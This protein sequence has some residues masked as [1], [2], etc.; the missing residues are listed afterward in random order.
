[1]V[2]VQNVQWVLDSLSVLLIVGV[3]VTAFN[4]RV[5]LWAG[6]I[7]ALWP[8]LASYGATPLADAPASWIIIGA[9][10]MFLLAAKRKSFAWAFG[11]GAL[12]GLSCWFRAN[13]MLLGFFW[14]IAI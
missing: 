13:A 1:P 11:A 6:G 4:W 5:G 10:W 2:S 12:V 3:G 9:P 8:L 14:A 7:A